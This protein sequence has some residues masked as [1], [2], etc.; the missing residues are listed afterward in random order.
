LATDLPEHVQRNRSAWDDMANDYAV[1]APKAWARDEPTW[2][3]YNIPEADIHALPEDVS[4]M[5][6]IDLGCGTG[7]FSAWMA[8]KGAKPV[9]IDNSPKQLETARRMQ[10]QFGIDFPL[11]L[12]NAEELPFADTSFDL[13]ISEYG[14]SIWCDPYRWIPEAARVLR[15]GGRVVFLGNG[16]L[17]LLCS[18]PEDTEET[19]IRE[20]LIRPWFGMHRFEWDDDEGVEFHLNHGDMIRLLRH[21]GFEIENLIE[22]QRPA[23][24]TKSISYVPDEWARKWP[25]EEIWCVRKRVG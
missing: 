5:D 16:P 8:R 23:D 9:G 17:V 2:G 22:V 7:Y 24:S 15:P 21:S 3:E 13:A 25:A 19:P 14:A 4:G 1:S 18:V 11:H 12:G 20:H 10:E 6:V